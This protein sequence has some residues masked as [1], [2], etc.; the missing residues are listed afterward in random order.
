MAFHI[1]CTLP[2]ENVYRVQNTEAAIRACIRVGIRAGIQYWYWCDSSIH[3]HPCSFVV[4][5][6]GTR[7]VSVRYGTRTFGEMMMHSRYRPLG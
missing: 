5:I 7:T 3:I 1:T 6:N 2:L 4:P